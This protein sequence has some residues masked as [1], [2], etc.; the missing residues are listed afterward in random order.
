MQIKSKFIENEWEQ[1]RKRE[2]V[3]TNRFYLNYSNWMKHDG[4]NGIGTAAAASD[5]TTWFIIPK[6]VGF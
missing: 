2:N 4:I 1:E 3:V 5:S 6:N